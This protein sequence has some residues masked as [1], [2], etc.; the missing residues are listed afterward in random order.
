MAAHAS[1]RQGRRS[2][3]DG[4][5]G[6]VAQPP[7][8][9]GGSWAEFRG[10]GG[11]R[12]AAEKQATNAC[13]PCTALREPSRE[14]SARTSKSSAENPFQ[15]LFQATP[16]L[17]SRFENTRDLFLFPGG[18]ALGTGTCTVHLCTLEDTALWNASWNSPALG[19]CRVCCGKALCCVCV[20]KVAVA[21][22]LQLGIILNTFYSPVSFKAQ[23][24]SG[25]HLIWAS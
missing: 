10:A 24:K 22:F 16:P 17:L 13:I 6:L 5:G 19:L 21:D 3:G 25:S 11:G 4:G 8:G 1:R 23:H 15:C 12:A 9:G 18:A 2:R 7:W 14:L 20:C